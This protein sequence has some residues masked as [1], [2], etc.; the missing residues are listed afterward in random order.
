[1]A[2]SNE[3]VRLADYLALEDSGVVADYIA[4]T[5]KMQ[6]ALLDFYG[7]ELDV[8][9]LIEGLQNAKGRKLDTIR[10]FIDNFLEVQAGKLPTSNL[11]PKVRWNATR[12]DARESSR[13]ARQSFEKAVKA[14]T[15]VGGLPSAFLHASTLMYH[16][17]AAS[18]SFLNLTK[19]ERKIG[20]ILGIE[21]AA[22]AAFSPNTEAAIDPQDIDVLNNKDS[23]SIQENFRANNNPNP[24]YIIESA[25]PAAA[26]GDSEIKNT[27]PP[28]RGLE[29][30]FEDAGKFTQTEYLLSPYLIKKLE[31]DASARD[32]MT[33]ILQEAEKNELDPVLF[34]NQMFRE[35]FHFNP[36]YIFGPDTSSAGAMGLGQITAGKG[37]EYGLE[38]K[39]DFFNP[40]KSI[41]AAARIMRDLTKDYNGDQ[42]LAMV[43]YNGGKSAIEFVKEELGRDNINSS[44]W[45]AFMN[46]RFEKLGNTS[47]SAWHV[48]TRQYVS[49]ITNLGWESA[50]RSWAKKLQGTNGL[51]YVAQLASLKTPAQRAIENVIR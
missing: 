6:S 45:I 31:E 7:P 2:I 51:N 35:S 46:S 19:R 16:A 9:A 27:R 33:W 4:K 20:M 12:D 17:S 5:P 26:P 50:Y 11:P 34:S 3:R 49:D 21:M 10:D 42:V 40:Q 38:K 22:L 15:K 37:K 8:D 32:Y 25:G 43:A 28:R 1:M 41:A 24:G 13:K 29:K 47:S 36:K 48:E 14:A 30:Q 39:E 44:D 18:L 23:Y